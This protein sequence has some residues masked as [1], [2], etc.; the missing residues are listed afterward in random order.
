MEQEL[1]RI[2]QEEWNQVSNRRVL[3][4][5]MSLRDVYISNRLID[6][7][8]YISEENSSPSTYLKKINFSNCVFGGIVKIGGDYINEIQFDN[9]AFQK[10]VDVIVGGFSFRE[11]CVFNE[12]LVINPRN[13]SLTSELSD[14]SVTGTLKVSGKV[15]KISRVNL[16]SKIVNQVLDLDSHLTEVTITDSSFKIIKANGSHTSTTEA[17]LKN[18]IAQKL[19]IQRIEKTFIKGSRLAEIDFSSL[20]SKNSVLEIT[21]ISICEQLDLS[22]TLFSRIHIADSEFGLMSLKNKL[23]TECILNIQKTSF[24]LLRFDKFFNSGSAT[25]RELKILKEGVVSIQSSNLGKIDFINCNFRDAELEFENSKITEA[26]LSET[27]FPK[28]IH[29]NRTKNYSQAQLAFGQ[30]ATAF[31]KQGDTV[32]ALEYNSRELQAHY[33]TLQW[34]SR[35][36]FKKLNLWLNFISNNFGRYW[37]LAVVFSFGVGIIFF[38]ALLIS[39]EQYHFGW[40]S[41]DSKLVPAFLKF[42]NPL[43]FIDTE[44]LFKKHG[45]IELNSWSYFWDFLG[46]VFVAY[47][48]YQTI[49]AFR[50][51]GRK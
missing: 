42:M 2:S 32:R 12:N 36:F 3:R 25:L 47:G 24:K 17:I 1:Q 29:S 16:N 13:F 45:V 11:G 44:D 51:F 14:I 7:D 38:L 10:N 6:R 15:G 5:D 40:P 4:S 39:T 21:D 9:C 46:R 49:Q 28:I 31:Q 20:V 18:V 34:L 30:L 27:D 43:R 50:R 37:V 23:A 8:V 41:F 19:E 35:D 26:F 22:M 33:G 48:F